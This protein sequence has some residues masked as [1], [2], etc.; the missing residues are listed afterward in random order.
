M[1]I[2]IVAVGK[3]KP[4]FAAAADEYTK[5]LQRICDIEVVS[6][7]EDGVRKESESILKKIKGNYILLDIGGEL[8]SS[9]EIAAFFSKSLSKG[10][11][12]FTFVIGGSDGVNDEVRQN[13]SM[14]LSF[15]RV[16]YPHQLMR[17]ILLE[18]IY[19]AMAINANLPYH[20]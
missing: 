12:E 18:Q 3:L 17:V 8:L 19:R 5:R 1:K 11:S 15:G 16:T 10:T 9:E 7:D 2:K 4:Y 13:A 14:K 6:L 20:K